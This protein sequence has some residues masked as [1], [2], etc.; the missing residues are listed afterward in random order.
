MKKIDDFEIIKNAS[1]ICNVSALDSD[2][3]V[4]IF[5]K[6]SCRHAKEFVANKKG[7]K[8]IESFVGKTMKAK[9]NIGGGKRCG[10]VNSAYIIYGYRKDPKESKVG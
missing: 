10:S 5:G 8:T 6:L 2:T 4:T 9:P 3:K 1:S 7:L